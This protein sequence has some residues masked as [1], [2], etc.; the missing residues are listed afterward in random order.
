[1]T[2]ELKS[3]EVPPPRP[4]MTGAPQPYRSLLKPDPR[5]GGTSTGFVAAV[6]LHALVVGAAFFLPQLFD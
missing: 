3:N 5:A 4:T 6:V 2:E 1:V